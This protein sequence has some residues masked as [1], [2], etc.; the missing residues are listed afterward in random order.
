M[1]SDGIG[2]S[3]GDASSDVA[4]EGFVDGLQRKVSAFFARGEIDVQGE[5]GVGVVESHPG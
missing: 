5:A 1:T 4:F 3:R 2:P